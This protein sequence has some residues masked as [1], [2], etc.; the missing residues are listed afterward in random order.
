MGR[1]RKAALAGVG[2]AGAAAALLSRRARLAGAG[3]AGAGRTG[4]SRTSRASRESEA[5]GT[6]VVTAT[7]LRPVDEVTRAWAAT[8]DTGDE[9]GGPAG[10]R[11]ASVEFGAAPGDR[12]TEVRAQAGASEA[13]DH[14][15]LARLRGQTPAQRQRERLRRFKALA[16]CGEV[17]TVEGQPSG[18]GPAQEAVTQAVTRRLRAWSGQ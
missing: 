17:V 3:G 1:V 2:V 14:G 9:S 15:V 11:P 6:A 5:A 16:E 10:D 13:G 18:R 12:G 7:I 4:T 8:D